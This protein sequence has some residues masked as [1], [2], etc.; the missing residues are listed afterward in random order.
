MKKPAISV[1]GLGKLGSPFAA[2]MAVKGFRVIGVDKNAKFV[3]AINK[4]E[5]PV[6]EPLLQAFLTRGRKNLR[7]T[8]NVAEAIANTDIS[9]L[10]VPTPSGKDGTF[11]NKFILQAIADIARE[12]KNKKT[13]HTIVVTSTVMPGSSA[14]V[15]KE[16]IEKA[17]GKRLGKDIGY[18]YNPEFIALGNVVSDMLDP[19]F[20]LIGEADT[21]SGALVA[22][23][24]KTVCG[25]TVPLQRM[26]PV[27]AEITKLAINTFVTNKISYAN[28]LADICERLPGADV[29]VV[30]AGVGSDSRIGRKYLK[31]AVAYGGPCFPRD[32]IA[33]FTMA[34]RL[35]ARVDLPRATHRLN[36]FQTGRLA[37]R[38]MKLVPK[39]GRIGIA[40]LAYKPDTP[41]I[42]R[43]A[44]VALA[45][46]LIRQRY[47][48]SLS[49]PLAAANAAKALKKKAV[50]VKDIKTLASK[51]DALVVMT[52]AGDFKSLNARALGARKHPLVIFDCWRLY[53]AKDF[54]KKAEIIALGRG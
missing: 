9:F 1:F 16:T 5:A 32:N 27:N 33:L 30:T 19:D 3:R 44:G 7:A 54:G 48:V 34:R 51:V 24:Y 25:K 23:I 20:I 50:V 36:E 53:K 35:G 14:G 31:G 29:D 4:G 41:V 46:Q 43:S 8:Q 12:L 42:E 26:S 28:M 52:P 2:V 13:R 37:R 21:R 22:Q 18:C 39:G 15:I 49:D 47:K 45:E 40:G 10:I 17:S 38:I 11:S 6:E